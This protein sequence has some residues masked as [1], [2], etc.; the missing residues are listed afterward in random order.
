MLVGILLVENFLLNVCKIKY[1]ASDDKLG[2][3]MLFRLYVIYSSFSLHSHDRV[4][5]NTL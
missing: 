5:L 1:I 4:I 3:V 2:A